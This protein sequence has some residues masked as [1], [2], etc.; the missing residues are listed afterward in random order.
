[1]VWS[2][3]KKIAPWTWLNVYLAR[4]SLTFDDFL[5]W[6]QSCWIVV[7]LES[8][9]YPVAMRVYSCRYSVSLAIKFNLYQVS[10]QTCIQTLGKRKAREFPKKVSTALICK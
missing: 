8:C 1:M 7:R 3:N 2:S 6:L 10:D 9:T 5:V 4:Q